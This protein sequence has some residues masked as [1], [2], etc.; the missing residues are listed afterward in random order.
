LVLVDSGDLFNEDEE[1][2]ADVVKASKLKADLI[3]EVLTSM[4]IDAV[5]VGELDLVLGINYLKELQ[6]KYNFPFVC[7]NLVDAKNIPIFK[8][9]VIKKVN[10]K[11]VGI[12]GVIGDTSEMAEKVKEITKNAAS[13]TDPLAAA[14]AVVKELTGKVDYIIALTHQGTNRDWVIA[15]RVNGIDLVV[16]GHDKQKTKDPNE[17]DKTLIVQ[18]GEKGQY[19]GLME[20]TLGSNK[21]SKNTLFAL[22]DD[23]PNDP[24]IKARLSKYN[25]DVAALYATPGG[26]TAKAATAEAKLRLSACEQCHADQ[27]AKWKTTDHARAYATLVK[28][29]KNFDP[30]CLMCHTTLFEK[31]GGFSVKLQQM[32]LVNIQCESCHGSR[33]EHMKTMKP[34][35]QKVQIS[36]CITCHTA[37][38]CP[39]FK[40]DEQKVMEK[41]K[42]WK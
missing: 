4:G 19:Q 25:D 9:Y 41:I 29:N 12:F 31:P 20:V 35:A 21:T 2:P 5:D 18:A 22:G 1:L 24:K 36:L 39:T 13:V 10:G 27:V 38:R 28:R 37:D 32:E 15:R 11:N 42:H 3:A 8:R 17:A 14:T 34:A 40:A 7:A 16:G 30:K 26:A 23:V 33:T 6:K